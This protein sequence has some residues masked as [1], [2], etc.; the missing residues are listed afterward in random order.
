MFEKIVST[1][2]LKHCTATSPTKFKNLKM[3]VNAGNVWFTGGKYSGRLKMNSG[4]PNGG[5]AYVFPA[6]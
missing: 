1:R 2:N 3:R 4:R 5:V 6:L